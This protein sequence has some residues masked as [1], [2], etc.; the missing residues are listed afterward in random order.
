MFS[1]NIKFRFQ[2]ILA[3]ILFGFILGGLATADTIY[4]QLTESTIDDMTSETEATLPADRSRT[5]IGIG[6]KVVCRIDPNSWEDKDCKKVDDGPWTD[7]N[8]TMGDKTWSA[9]GT[10]G[11][12]SPTTGN[13][14][15]LTA[16]KTPAGVT[17]EVD[18]EDSGAKYIDPVLVKTKPFSVIAPDG[19][20]VTLDEDLNPGTAGPPNNQ[21]G[22]SSRFL[23][24]ITPTSVNF[25]NAELRMSF[26]GD[27]WTWPDGTNDSFSAYDNDYGVT[28]IDGQHNRCYDT[29]TEYPKPIGRLDNDPDPNKVNYV[30]HDHAINSQEKYKN[31]DGD[32]ETF[33]SNETHVFEYRGSDQKGRV[34]LN[35]STSDSG[36]W[37]GPW[38]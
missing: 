29:A 35:S 17:V 23:C 37:M 25:Y 4:D 2:N 27:N 11:T 32:W 20:E 31:Q 36:D 30:D 15:T 7:V 26:P 9:S 24:T 16:S 28:T 10:G 1:K 14:T 3:L 5:T 19:I 21:I 22:S 34:T 13:S 12:V 8:D 38:Q 33:I 18:I 6:E